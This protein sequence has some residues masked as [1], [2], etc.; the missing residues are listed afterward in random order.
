MIFLL[1]S[2]SCSFILLKIKG[3]LLAILMI[4]TVVLTVNNSCKELGGING[5]I[6]GHGLILTE[7]IALLFL[8]LV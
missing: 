4:I 5:D 8:S 6:A 2:I 1:I 3:I 7:S